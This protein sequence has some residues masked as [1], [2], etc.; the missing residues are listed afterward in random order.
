MRQPEAAEREGCAVLDFPASITTV[1]FA[2][3][4]HGDEALDALDEDAATRQSAAQAMR[5]AHDQGW[6]VIGRGGIRGG[7]Y[8]HAEAFVDSMAAA[9]GAAAEVQCPAGTVLEWAPGLTPDEYE[10]GGDL[11]PVP[12]AGARLPGPRFAPP[13]RELLVIDADGIETLCPSPDAALAR[14]RDAITDLAVRLARQYPTQEELPAELLAKI[15]RLGDIPPGGMHLPLIEDLV[16]DERHSVRV[17]WA[18]CL[19]WG[20]FRQALEDPTRPD[21][22]DRASDGRLGQHDRPR[23]EEPVSALMLTGPP[24][25]GKTE[26]LAVLSDTLVAEDAHAAIEVEALTSAYPAH[27]VAAARAVGAIHALLARGGG[28]RMPSVGE[29][30]EFA[31]RRQRVAEVVVR[32]WRGAVVAMVRGF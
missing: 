30:G 11:Q 27:R 7:V 21:L 12:L 17:L 19:R 8:C 5:R 1:A 25:A 32:W 29:R 24:G 26:V 16:T 22:A 18:D 2:A 23:T 4:I 13:G 10:P 9:E 31:C 14:V 20:G 28:G 3:A 6:M 15:D